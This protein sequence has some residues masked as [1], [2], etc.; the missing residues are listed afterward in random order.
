M[1][2]PEV[3][4]RLILIFDGACG[5]CTRCMRLVQALDRYQR[6]TAV[7]F[8]QRGVPEAAGLT[9]AACAH[10]AWA[11]TASGKRFAGAA[12]VNVALAVALGTPIPLVVYRLPLLQQVQDR[13]YAWVAAH[14]QHFPGD[15]PYCSQYPT[16]CA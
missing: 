11:I 5:F 15:R 4:S 6:V 1:P 7:P 3:P 13:L 9:V 16:E 10:S 2:P 12:A 8:Q 14:R